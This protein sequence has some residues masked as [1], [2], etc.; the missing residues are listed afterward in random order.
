MTTPDMRCF[1]TFI[2]A[3]PSFPETNLGYHVRDSLSMNNKNNETHYITEGYLMKTKISPQGCQYLDTDI[4][5]RIK[6]NTLMRHKFIFIMILFHED[7]KINIIF[8]VKR[9]VA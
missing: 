8:F 9:I 3:Q 2:L 5:I 7:D 1:R 4:G 6:Y